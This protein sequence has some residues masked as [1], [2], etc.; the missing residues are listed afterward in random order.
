[1]RSTALVATDHA[2]RYMSQLVKH[3]AHKLPTQLEADHGRIEFPSGVCE[4]KAGSVLTLTCIAPAETMAQ[5]QDV[6][7]RHLIRFAF[8]ENELVVNWGPLEA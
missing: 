6:V 1:M 3:F 7:A 4:A 2:A 5:L 8:R